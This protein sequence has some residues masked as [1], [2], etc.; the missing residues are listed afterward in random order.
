MLPASI[1]LRD[2]TNTHQISPMNKS[3]VSPIMRSKLTCKQ[4]YYQ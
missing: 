2:I 3:Q 4:N 1:I